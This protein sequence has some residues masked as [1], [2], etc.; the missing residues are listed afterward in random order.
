[1]E[2]AIGLNRKHYCIQHWCTVRC[3]RIFFNRSVAFLT[4][5]Q[6]RH[7]CQFITFRLSQHFHTSI[8]WNGFCSFDLPSCMPCTI[9]IFDTTE[10]CRKIIYFRPN[11]IFSLLIQKWLQFVSGKNYNDLEARLMRWITLNLFWWECTCCVRS[12]VCAARTY[13]YDCTFALS[14]FSN[15]VTEQKRSNVSMTIVIHLYSTNNQQVIPWVQGLPIAP[16]SVHWM[17]NSADQTSWC[18]WLP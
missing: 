15:A 16:Y 5:I 18:W 8:I 13:T 3:A 14:S 6:T 10:T 4:R 17:Q 2:Y 9:H 11:N 7:Y 1:M 12:I